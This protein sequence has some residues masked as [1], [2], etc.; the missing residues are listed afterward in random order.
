MLVIECYDPTSTSY[1]FVKEM[2]LYKNADYEPFIK[3]ENSVDFI[4]DSS[5]ATNGSILI[6]QTS[7]R[8]YFFDMKTGIRLS[9]VKLADEFVD[10]R[11]CFDFQNNIFYNFKTA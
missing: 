1:K 5:F 10:S 2:F 9:K 3:K 7:N 8:A 6:I 4:K 11:I